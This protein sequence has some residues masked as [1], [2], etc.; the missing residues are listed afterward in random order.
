MLKINE[1]SVT[2]QHLHL[3]LGFLECNRL[4]KFA[5]RNGKFGA[6]GTEFL[7]GVCDTPAPHCRHG[8]VYQKPEISVIQRSKTARYLNK[9]SRPRYV[10]W[11]IISWHRL[12][13]TRLN[14]AEKEMRQLTKSRVI[15]DH[16]L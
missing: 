10:L 14:K 8:P 4:N 7:S 1:H 3:L 2:L 9:R 16:V 12:V 11:R 5:D 6:L 15:K 13:N